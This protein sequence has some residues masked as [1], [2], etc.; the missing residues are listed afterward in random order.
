[1]DR[2]ASGE[3]RL[4]E[5][6]AGVWATLRRSRLFHHLSATGTDIRFTTMRW[7][8]AF[9]GFVQ[10]IML[11][12]QQ[13][14][15]LV[16]GDNVAPDYVGNCAVTASSNV[17]LGCSE[18]GHFSVL[19]SFAADGSPAWAKGYSA[20]GSTHPFA[21]V[22]ADGAD[23]LL[24]IRLH[25]DTLMETPGT[26]TALHILQVA[27][28][29]AMGDPEWV[30]EVSIRQPDL[31][32]GTP[33]FSTGRC[34]RSSDGSILVLAKFD[35]VGGIDS[36]WIICKLSAT[37]GLLWARRCD[38]VSPFL[39]GRPE[40]HD[41]GNGAFTVVCGREE[42]PN[43]LGRTLIA[44]FT[45]SG[46]LEWFR[47]ME[48]T[49][50]GVFDQVHCG[51]SIGAN[52]ELLVM[53]GLTQVSGP[54]LMVTHVDA[55]GTWLSSDTYT[56]EFFGSIDE[57]SSAVQRADG[58]WTVSTKNSLVHLRLGI[59]GVLEGAHTRSQRDLG[60]V[61]F[62]PALC[63]MVVGAGRLVFGGALRR[64][65]PIQS[66][67]T[68]APL[69]ESY[70]PEQ[71]ELGCQW[72]QLD[73]SRTAVPASDIL[74]TNVQG[75][76]SIEQGNAVAAAPAL[77]WTVVDLTMPAITELCSA[78]IGVSEA[79]LEAGAPMLV[80]NIIAPGGPLLIQSPGAGQFTVRGALGNLLSSMAG[81]ESSVTLVG[82][83]P[84]AAGAYLLQWRARDGSGDRVQRF[85]VQ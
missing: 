82:T 57:R 13:P 44:R 59:D 48:H 74:M 34:L 36:Y 12:A 40:V 61:T 33:T 51:A 45:A 43:G 62:T 14:V 2:V 8:F 15:Q 7:P 73:V 76:S 52:G 49:G 17:V 5:T 58:G 71:E 54:T 6:T 85:I 56:Y 79:H 29:G 69:F 28:I 70:D 75:P 67:T 3:A 41:A 80:A 46:A 30:S 26:D 78:Q 4:R 53:N 18:T 31:D 11:H 20:N 83:A 27:R 60:G 21:D 9:I 47:S 55:T 25:H 68:Y 24:A 19:R 66:S 10:A 23:A 81:A 39:N 50:S 1:M 38:I 64:H 65:D 37:G 32:P 63:E 16:W 72:E 35:V 42:E 84:S 22:R 77:P